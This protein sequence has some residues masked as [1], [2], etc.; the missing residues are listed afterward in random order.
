MKFKK[1]GVLVLAGVLAVSG[2]T[3]STVSAMESQEKTVTTNNYYVITPF[4]NSI[5]SII[6]RISAD[7]N[8]LYP[9]V[10]IEAKSSSATVSGTMY[11][12]KLVSGKWTM[13]TSWS[14]SSTGS[15]FLSK[16]YQG[17]YGATYRVKIAV[18]VDGEKAEAFPRNYTL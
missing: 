17:T 8:T 15:A 16:T 12:E 13:V 7:N 9:E 10:D 1:I 18:T 2:S 14:I 6:P 4:W 5:S 11:L 3:H